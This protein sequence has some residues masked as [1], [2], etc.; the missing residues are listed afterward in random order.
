[1][2]RGAGRALASGT[3]ED[4]ERRIPSALELRPRVEPAGVLAL[5]ARMPNL[6]ND[7]RRN[8][9]VRFTLRV[10]YMSFR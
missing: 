8:S 4:G 10:V 7:T 6:I 5:Q 2:G 9:V 1:M 3:H